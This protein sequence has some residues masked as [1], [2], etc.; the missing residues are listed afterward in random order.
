MLHTARRRTTGAALLL[1]ALLLG[2]CITRPVKE[3]VFKKDAI[4]VTLRSEKRWFRTVDKGFS[5]PITIAPV[6]MA[7]ILSRIDLRPGHEDKERTPAIPTE[8]LFPIAEGISEALGRATPD[9][10]VVVMA[11]RETK[12]FGIFDHDYLTSFV[13]Y[14]RDERLYLHMGHHDWQIPPRR[15][16]R[17]PEPRIGD[18]PERFRLYPGTAMALVDSQSLAIDWRDPIFARPTRT[19]VLPTG[20]VVRKTILME[21][22]PEVDESSESVEPLPGD[23]SPEQLRALADAEEARRSG[24][25]TE[26]EYRARRREILGP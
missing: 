3:P 6:R 23:L 13:V 10:E 24:K 2:G 22:P 16:E 12:R 9:Q 25:M 5:H 17:L 8:F 21:S 20:E 15:D 1:L 18:H 19:K 14:V 7:Y 26:A 11:V 4:E